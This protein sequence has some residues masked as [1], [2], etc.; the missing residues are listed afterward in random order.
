MAD[1]RIRWWGQLNLCLK[2][3]EVESF[4]E[5][6]RKRGM[7]HRGLFLMLW[8]NFMEKE[9]EEREREE[10]ARE[11]ARKLELR[12]ALKEHGLGG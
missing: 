10:W 7:R 4:R 11:K 9:R 2:P 12:K 6:A 5:E 8:D 3:E 1:K